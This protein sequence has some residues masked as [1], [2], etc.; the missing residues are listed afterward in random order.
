MPRRPPKKKDDP[1]PLDVRFVPRFSEAFIDETIR[2]WSPRYGRAISHEEAAESA[3]NFPG[4]FRLLREWQ[5][6]EGAE[7]ALSESTKSAAGEDVRAKEDKEPPPGPA[8]LPTGKKIPVG[9]G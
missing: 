8:M 3:T 5:R 4:F 1:C 9:G 7:K 2:A 6:R